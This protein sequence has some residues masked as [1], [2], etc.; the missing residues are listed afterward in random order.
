MNEM[1]K[2]R[3]QRRRFSAE[4]RAQWVEMYE[5]SAQ[6]LREFSSEHGLIESNLSRWRR[7]LRAAANGK[8]GRGSFVEVSVS[9]SAPQPAVAAPVRV[10]LCGGMT[11]EVTSG[12]DALWLA[13]V[14]RA[15]SPGQG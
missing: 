13:Q 2:T 1:T 5:R 11:M 3:T 12:T 10:C 7:H 9:A 4:E 6:S 15:L 8:R 14:L